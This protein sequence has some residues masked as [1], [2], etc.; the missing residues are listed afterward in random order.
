[1]HATVFEF[2]IF[3]C[4]FSLSENDGHFDKFIIARWAKGAQIFSKELTFKGE[5][6]DL[7]SFPKFKNFTLSRSE[8]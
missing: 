8:V 2:L 7:D 5:S 1:M 4:L 3:L 6:H